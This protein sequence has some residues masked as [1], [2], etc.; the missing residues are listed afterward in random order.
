MIY[1]K[2]N[3]GNR[4]R[5]EG[6]EKKKFDLTRQRLD[7]ECVPELRK[8]IT[9]V[10]SFDSHTFEHHIDMTTNVQRLV[11]NFDCVNLRS[12]T[13]H[14]MNVYLTIAGRFNIIK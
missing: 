12:Q 7:S 6:K 11:P 14:K 3:E 10:A 9:R 2:Q 4:H 1:C 8:Q 5:Y 13:G